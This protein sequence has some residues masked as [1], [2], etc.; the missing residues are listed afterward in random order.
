MKLFLSSYEINQDLE[1][2][3]ETK[4]LFVLGSFFYLKKCKKDYL[5]R[6]MNYVKT[7]CKNFILDS[8]AFTFI[9]G[10]KNAKNYIIDNIDD[11][12]EQYANFIKKWEIKNY[13]ELDLDSILGY[14]KVKEIRKKLEEKVGH[15][16]I[17]VFHNLYRTKNDLDEILKEY[18]YIAISNFNGSKSKKIIEPIKKIV[19]YANS[20][21]VKV[22][23]LALTG[24]N[25]TKNINF[26][27]VDSSTWASCIRFGSI[28]KFNFK[29]K[30][31]ERKNISEKFKIINNNK[32][33]KLL[34]CYCGKEWKKYQVY[35]DIFR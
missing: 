30:K 20:K 33:S 21:N 11:Y 17:P 8:G 16:S 10:N 13:I 24:N 7:Q 6:Y 2:L 27:S 32:T 29:T 25:F 19:N 9:T 31:L 12:I 14:E 34:L 5:D 23:G 35:L 3:T 22:H 4:P 1:I 28:S 26:Y 15:K 18:D